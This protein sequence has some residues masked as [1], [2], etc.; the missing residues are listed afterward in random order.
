MQVTGEATTSQAAPAAGAA[1]PPPAKRQRG[2]VPVPA[3][4]SFTSIVGIWDWWTGTAIG[5]K[6]NGEAPRELEA[7]GTAW[8]PG[9]AARSNFSD[10]LKAINAVQRKAVA[11][12]NARG[13]VVNE[14]DAAA[15]L[16]AEFA[17]YNATTK[18]HLTFYNWV[19]GHNCVVPS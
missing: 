5:S 12:T 1:V 10:V 7:Q 11:L 6:V 8:R 13:R 2:I 17:E 9:K 14:R 19:R 3:V 18:P 16:D 15:T 4:G